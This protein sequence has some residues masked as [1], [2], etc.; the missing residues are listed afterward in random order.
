MNKVQQNRFESLYQSHV[1]AL[2]RQGKAD[3]TIEGYARAVRRITD[4]FDICP[5]CLNEQHFKDYFDS[6]IKTHSWS[7][8][9]ID[10]NGLRS[11]VRI[12]VT[13]SLSRGH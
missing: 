7:I 5:D 10:R 4:Y 12:L 8:I 1:N 13:L 6:L 11:C 2:R 9:K 3:K